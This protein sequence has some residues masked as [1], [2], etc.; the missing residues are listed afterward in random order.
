MWGYRRVPVM[1]VR[2]LVLGIFVV[3]LS[4]SSSAVAAKQA[5]SAAAVPGQVDADFDGDGLAD[6]AIYRPQTTAWH[7]LGGATTTFGLSTDVPVPADYDGNGVTDIAVFR[8]SVGGWYR[9]GQPTV[10]LGAS[11]DL[12]VPADYDG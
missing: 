11:G 2:G 9:P 12:P 6:F 3:A 5:E 10:H 8:E 7:V 1:A 4:A